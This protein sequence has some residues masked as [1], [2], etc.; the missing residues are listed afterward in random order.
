MVKYNL[1][2]KCSVVSYLVWQRF[3]L[4]DLLKNVNQLN[5]SDSCI[6]I[7]NFCYFRVNSTC[8]GGADFQERF[9]IFSEPAYKQQHNGTFNSTIIARSPQPE[10]RSKSARLGGGFENDHDS[11]LNSSIGKL[12]QEAFAK[13]QPRANSSP[14]PC[15]NDNISISQ[16]S[17]VSFLERKIT[18]NVTMY[19]LFLFLSVG[20]NISLSVYLFISYIWNWKTE[21]TLFNAIVVYNRCFYYLPDFRKNSFQIWRSPNDWVDLKTI[22]NSC[23]IPNTLPRNELLWQLFRGL[24]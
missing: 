9:S 16:V 22:T 11:D 20:F 10:F 3:F 19:S 5:W 13:L 8:G 24:K 6:L 18:I 1:V 7:Y 2:I 4:F 17:D 12:S 23:L 15:E 21:N 14:K